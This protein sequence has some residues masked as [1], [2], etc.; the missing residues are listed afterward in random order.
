M[1][2]VAKVKQSETLQQKALPFLAEA[3][4][5]ARAVLGS[6]SPCSLASRQD[7][8]F[9]GNP[10][11]KVVGVYLATTSPEQKE[12]VGGKKSRKDGSRLSLS[13]R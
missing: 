11:K 8:Y 1:Y 13:A 6:D 2:I 7:V 10:Q 9:L 12:C 4:Y 3:T 5:V